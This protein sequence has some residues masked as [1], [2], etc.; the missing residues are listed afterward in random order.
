M[1]DVYVECFGQTRTPPETI[2]IE[3]A[4]RFPPPDQPVGWI[5]VS[6]TNLQGWWPPQDPSRYSWLLQH[7]PRAKIGKTI[8]LYYLE[9]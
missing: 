8:W 4:K 2:G 7:E 5:A 1:T 6:L 9:P 3:G